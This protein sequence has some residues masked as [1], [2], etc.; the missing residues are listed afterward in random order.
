MSEK[1]LWTSAEIAAATSGVCTGRWN[2]AGV[3]ID[4]RTVQPGDVF[5]A[6]KGPNFDAHDFVGEA[7]AK[8]AAGAI[9]N[10]IPPQTPPER[11]VLTPDSFQALQ[12][13]G[14][15]GR[16]RSPAKIIAVTGSVG[17][18]GCKE[19]LRQVLPAFAS[20]GSYN[21]HWGA[22]LSLARLPREAAYGAFEL[23]M[24]H[25]G[26]L[27]PL[28]RMTRPHVALVTAIAPVH[29]EFFAGLE[30]IA[31]AKSEIFEGVMPDGAAILNGD[32]AY[33][34]LLKNAAAAKGIKNILRFGKDKGCDA[35]LD[36]FSLQPE[37]SHVKAEVLGAPLSYRVGAPGFHWVKNSLAVLLCA[38]AVGA[39]V[40]EIA[41]RLAALDLAKG[42]GTATEIPFARGRFTLVD[43]SYNASPA[44]VA[45]AISVLAQRAPRGKGRLLLVLGDMRELGKNSEPFHLDL[46]PMIKEAGIARVFCCGP[47]MRLLHESLPKDTQGGWK[48]DSGQL[49][50]LVTAAMRDGDIVTVKGSFSMGMKKVVDA[51][52]AMQEEE[53][54]KKQA[55]V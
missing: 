52:L 6:L 22:P 43:E 2:A 21:N 16:D 11:L 5:V 49:A 25:A 23:G 14:K 10:Y 40:R 28:A 41:Q 48:P 20:Q 45:A 4:S 54:T 18:T 36:E 51:L 24:N 37:G 53:N 9:V 32:D 31:R 13:L 7:L 33:F 42:R 38:G 12:A 29:L 44:A 34:D 47:F 3:S 35:R 50:P 8:G 26:E 46:A 55:A 19:A 39:D 17:K 27:G 1:V 30:D 15:A